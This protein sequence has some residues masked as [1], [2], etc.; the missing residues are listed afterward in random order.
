MKYKPIDINC[1]DCGGLAEF[2]EPFEFLSKG[3][4]HHDE[5]KPAHQ[6]GGWTVLERFP[7]QLPW[8]APSGSDQYLRGGGDSSKGG[9]PVL[10]NGLVQC[11]H[12][13]SNRKH[14]LNWPI[15]AYW[16]WEIRGELL[17]AWDKMHAKIVLDFVRNTARPSRHSP[18]LMYIPS[19]FL[20]AKVREQVVQ[21]MERS[22][23]CLAREQLGT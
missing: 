19:H 10:T 14:K 22:L 18:R 21:K 1:P 2:E 3:D 12:Y 9:Y 16:Q 5:M 4:V 13:H 8:K 23:Q 15:D 20:S 6:W 11:S 17:W 7:S